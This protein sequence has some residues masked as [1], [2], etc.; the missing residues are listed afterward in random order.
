MNVDRLETSLPT[1]PGDAEHDR[2]AGDRAWRARKASRS[3]SP[4]DRTRVLQQYR[5]SQLE[6]SKTAPGPEPCWL[7][8][9]PC[10]GDLGG[11]TKHWEFLAAFEESAGLRKKTLPAELCEEIATLLGYP[12]APQGKRMMKIAT[13]EL[14]WCRGATAGE[15]RLVL[16]RL[17]RSKPDRNALDNSVREG[18]VRT[19]MTQVR[20]GS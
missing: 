13:G 6:A 8:G 14:D 7:K 2:Y 18:Y 5:A 9:C 10:E 3:L 1:K 4:T 15:W 16:D 17:A 12:P 11:G 20:A 19:V